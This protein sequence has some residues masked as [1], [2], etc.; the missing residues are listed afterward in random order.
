MAKTL[1]VGLTMA[2]LKRKG[3]TNLACY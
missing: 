3:A 1:I 2:T